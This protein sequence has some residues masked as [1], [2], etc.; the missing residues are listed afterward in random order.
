MI[1]ANKNQEATTL[2]MINTQVRNNSK[3]SFT[4][5]TAS[6]NKFN[7]V[8]KIYPKMQNGNCSPLLLALNEESK[9]YEKG[10]KKT[11]ILN[12]TDNGNM[13]IKYNKKNSTQDFSHITI[14][15]DDVNKESMINNQLINLH[16]KKGSIL[17]SLIN[18]K[19]NMIKA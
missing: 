17:L 1:T 10:N 16:K 12:D 3:R 11:E 9:L 18:K 8:P 14:K 2:M 7:F 4:V 13:D 15:E 5:M 19:K 6:V